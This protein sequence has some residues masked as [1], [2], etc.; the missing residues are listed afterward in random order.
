MSQPVTGAAASGGGGGGGAFGPWQVESAFVNLS[1]D[2][3]D[4]G[5]VAMPGPITFDT[6]K[7]YFLFNTYYASGFLLQPANLLDFTTEPNQVLMPFNGD[8][9]LQG[10]D[11]V[12]G[13]LVD[14]NSGLILLGTQSAFFGGTIGRYAL[15]APQSY[16]GGGGPPQQCRLPDALIGAGF[17]GFNVG[18]GTL[19]KEWTASGTGFDVYWG[20]LSRTVT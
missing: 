17:I 7:Q 3:N 12:A 9:V 1:A 19:E 5:P 20:C 4:G 6:A 2:P 8:G 18:T 15:T 10:G 11:D 14:G 13:V 16:N